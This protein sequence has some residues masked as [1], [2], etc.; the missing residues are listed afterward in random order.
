MIAIAYFSLFILHLRLVHVAMGL[1]GNFVWATEGTPLLLIEVWFKN[2]HSALFGIRVSLVVEVLVLAFR[3]RKN[4]VSATISVGTRKHSS[5]G[6][7]TTSH[8]KLSAFELYQRNHI[9]AEK[10]FHFSIAILKELFRC[11]ISF[12][13]EKVHLKEQKLSFQQLSTY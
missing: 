7:E 11:Y 1:P 4:W 9:A 6:T 3:V 13:S 8:F 12:V 5:L 2:L 10:H